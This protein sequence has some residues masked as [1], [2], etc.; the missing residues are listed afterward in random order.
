MKPC[1]TCGQPFDA[2][3]WQIAKQDWECKGCRDLRRA[4][5]WRSRSAQRLESTAHRAKQA[6]WNAVFHAIERGDLVR[7]PCEVCGGTHVEA[8]HDDYAKPLDVRWLCPTHHKA[9]HRATGSAQ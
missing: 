9:H 2:K 3:P 5:Y 8:H 6:I 7:Q 4:P 1:R